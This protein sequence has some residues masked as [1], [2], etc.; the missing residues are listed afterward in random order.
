MLNQT[1]D[2][3]TVISGPEIRTKT[4]YWLCRCTCGNE[5]WANQYKLV[6]GRKKSC[7]CLRAEKLAK[8]NPKHGHASR[9]NTSRT[10]RTWTNMLNRCTN[11]NA[12]QFEYY[13]GRGITVCER[14]YAFENFY[15]DMGDRPLNTTINRIDNDGNYEPNNCEWADESVRNKNRRPFD[16]KPSNT[17]YISV[18]GTRYQLKDACVRFGV[19]YSAV[20]HWRRRHNVSCEEAFIS[21]LN[22]SELVG[23]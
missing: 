22:N 6:A 7:G 16:W 17:L 18:E 8:G 15:S 1:Y 3:L 14:W 9:E 4:P 12:T 5:T 23:K 13:G 21:R 2:R 19:S 11:P 20:Q 10:Y